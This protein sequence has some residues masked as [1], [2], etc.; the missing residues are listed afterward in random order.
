MNT[1]L[2]SHHQVSACDDASSR[3]HVRSLTPSVSSP[4]RAGGTLSPWT[5]PPA[6]RPNVV[7]DA[8]WDR[9]RARTRA[10]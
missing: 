9:E 8:R 3:V 6:S 7:S 4:V 2:V 10:R 5:V 1:V